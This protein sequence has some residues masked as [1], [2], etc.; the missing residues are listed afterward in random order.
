MVSKNIYTMYMRSEKDD[1]APIF[2]KNSK[3]YHLYLSFA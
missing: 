1:L 3:P 2:L